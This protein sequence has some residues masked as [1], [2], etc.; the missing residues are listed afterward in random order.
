MCFSWCLETRGLGTL[1]TT[2]WS[3]DGSWAGFSEMM[4]LPGNIALFGCGSLG[5]CKVGAGKVK[6][7]TGWQVV[8]WDLEVWD[9]P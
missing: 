8:K 3:L 1:D 2:D 9:S 7:I 4:V 6:G 5:A